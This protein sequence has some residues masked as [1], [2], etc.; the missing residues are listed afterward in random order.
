M[1]D[2]SR[3]TYYTYQDYMKG[4]YVMKF[5][6]PKIIV[7]DAKAEERAYGGQKCDNGW[8]SCCFKG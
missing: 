2:V 1:S 8:N 4:E 3:V 6:A 7:L 5:E